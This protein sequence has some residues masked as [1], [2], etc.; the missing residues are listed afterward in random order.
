MPA[1]I[2]YRW[3][4]EGLEIRFEPDGIWLPALDLWL[5]PTVP[6]AA[7]WLSHAHSDHAREV[8][9]RTWSTPETLAMYALRWPGEGV[10][11]AVAYGET[12]EWRGARCTVLPA[13]HILG[14]AQ[15]L[16]EYEDER[17]VYTGDIKLQAP[18]CGALTEIA[19]C[20]RLIVE[21]TFGLPIYHFL[22]REQAAARIAAVARECLDDGI[23]PVFYAY[24][25]GRG[26]E[27]T[28]VLCEAGLPVAVHGA[29]ARFIPFYE[30][31]GYRCDGWQPYDSR[32]TRGKALV[33]TP[34][35][36]NLVEASGKNVR[37]AYVSGWAALANARARVG[38]EELIPYSDHASFAELIEIV[39]RSRA[40]RVD[41][42]HGYTE[43][44][45]HILRQRG[46]DA[47]PAGALGAREDDAREE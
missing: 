30:Q 35:M 19:P 14:A 5:D 23:T 10:R 6:V 25:L 37:V 33:L 28:H 24:A 39:T 34:G 31:A 41:L 43:P 11:E 17:V 29:I 8:H 20:D 42:V 1:S 45:A 22:S 15:L 16:I 44:F 12:F 38:A 13:G 21:C 26:Q 2:F 9:G 27:V 18:L 4:G 47:Y 36:R 3:R 46:I 32:Q 40:R 7:A